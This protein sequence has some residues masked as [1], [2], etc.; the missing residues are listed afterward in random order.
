MTDPNGIVGPETL[1][2]TSVG[3]HLKVDDADQLYNQTVAA[4]AVVVS[5]M[6]DQFFS[7]RAGSVKDPFGHHWLIMTTIE[8]ISPEEMQKRYSAIH[9]Q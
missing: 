3:I 1:G 5:P 4:G 7:E 9:E 2:N 8:D 6:A